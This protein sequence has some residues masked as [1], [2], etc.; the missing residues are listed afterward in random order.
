MAGSLCDVRRSG[1][2]DVGAAVAAPGSGEE[3]STRLGEFDLSSQNPGPDSAQ[4]SL[5]IDTGSLLIYYGKS[6]HQFRPSL[7]RCEHVQHITA[8]TEGRH[9]KIHD[10]RGAFGRR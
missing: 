5:S 4:S 3:L 10:L 8:G 9:G 7:L 2:P 1:W 6:L